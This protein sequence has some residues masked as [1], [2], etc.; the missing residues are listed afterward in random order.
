MKL[1]DFIDQHMETILVEWDAFAR[2]LAPAEQHLSAPALRDHAREILQAI[3]LDI[4]TR[5]NPRQQY[6]KSLGQAPDADPVDSAA[7]VHGALRQASSFSLTQL[8]AEFRA[9][10]AT[11]LRLWLPH[12]SA[13][14][15]TAIEQMVRFNEA[16]DQALAESIATYTASAERSRE[17]FLAILGHDLRAPLSTMSLVGQ[18]LQHPGLEADKIATLAARIRRGAHLMNSMVDDLLGYTHSQLAGGMPMSLQHADIGQVCQAAMED[19]TSLHPDSRFQLSRDGDLSG[20]FDGVRLHQLCTNLFANAAQYGDKACPIDIAALGD[21][22]AITVRVNN[23]GPV[24]PA[25]SL[26]AIFQALVQLDT[27]DDGEAGNRPRTSLGL[28]L[29]VAREIALAHG[30]TLGATSSEA[31]GTTFTLRLPRRVPGAVC[32]ASRISA[33]I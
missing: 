12:V 3:A 26:H 27:A 15:G 1:H 16:I 2:T 29:F 9:L 25:D 32:A 18:L 28:G 5:Q 24:I 10:R 20:D 30:G 23:R 4:R 13:M 31:E 19:A 6:E 33:K 21:A 22:D 8:C 17:L 11:V 14:S 7:A